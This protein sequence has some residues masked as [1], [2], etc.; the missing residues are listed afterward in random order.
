MKLQP[1]AKYV[2]HLTNLNVMWVKD[3]RS[4]CVHM[5]SCAGVFDCGS[6]FVCFQDEK[7][8]TW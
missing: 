1:S 6:V 4:I 8:S 2:H 3:Y 5:Y 7:P